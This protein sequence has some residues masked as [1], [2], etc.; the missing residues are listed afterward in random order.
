MFFFS[1]FGIFSQVIKVCDFVWFYF[2]RPSDGYK[3]YQRSPQCYAV[4]T[5]ATDGI[6]KSLA[7]DLYRKGFNLIVHGRNEEKLEATVEEIK[8]FRKDGIVESFIFDA[9][10]TSADYASIARRFGDLN[11]TLFINNVSE[12]YLEPR[13]FGK[14]EEWSE[15]DLLSV[16][17]WTV[18]FPTL[19]MRAFLPSLRKTSLLHPV[20]VV[21]NGSSSPEFTVPHTP[22][23]TATEAFVQR[24]LSSLNADEKFVPGKSNIE[25]MYVHVGSAQSNPATGPADPSPTTFDDRAARIVKTFG[26]GREDVVPSATDRVQLTIIDNFPGFSDSF[27]GFI[28]SLL[29]FFSSLLGFFNSLLGFVRKLSGFVRQGY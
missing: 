1:L 9:T 28:S 29:G 24:L 7:K 27:P 3:K 17:G 11:I 19:L 16:I 13:R 20:L 15:D 26:S 21:F 4:I 6:G 2:F 10:N 5:G 14:F 8:A 18:H 23:H 25:F 22:L 12:T